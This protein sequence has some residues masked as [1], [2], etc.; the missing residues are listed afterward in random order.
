M[1]PVSSEHQI[2]A[3]RL[4]DQIISGHEG[5]WSQPQ[6]VEESGPVSFHHEH[7]QSEDVPAL[8]SATHAQTEPSWQ[9]NRAEHYHQSSAHGMEA[10]PVVPIL[11][12]V[13][14]YVRGE[15]HVSTYIPPLPHIP[16]SVFAASGQSPN[17]QP[18]ALVEHHEHQPAHHQPTTSEPHIYQPQ[19]ILPTPPIA[20][21]YQRPPSPEPVSDPE[22]PTFEAP[23]AEWDGARYVPLRMLT[24]VEQYTHRSQ[25]TTAAELKARGTQS[26]GKDIHHVRRHQPVP[27]SSI[28][29]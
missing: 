22:P 13:P 21:L 26:T 14:Q 10:A 12:A 29:S 16:A 24:F 1:P 7:S 15:E 25:R 8:V 6:R 19:P 3:I 9:Q 20:Q 23:R 27:T 17:R 28:L 5:Q 4:N 11:S 18:E 2:P